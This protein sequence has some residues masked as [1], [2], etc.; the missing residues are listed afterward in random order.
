MPSSWYASD[1]D[2]NIEQ[3]DI[4]LDFPLN[5]V[6]EFPEDDEIV[7]IRQEPLDLIVL[8]QTCYIVNGPKVDDILLAL[9]QNYDTTANDTKFNWLREKNAIKGLVDGNNSAFLLLPENDGV[10]K[11]NWSFINFHHLYTVPYG[12]I[13]KI[14]NESPNRLR[15]KS[16]YLEHVSQGFAKYMMKVALPETLERFKTYKPSS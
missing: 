11:F 1:I 9:I 6:L 12:Y 5:R 15:L 4:F 14:A 13:Q 3:G 8:T 10:V 16:P 7:D 2:A